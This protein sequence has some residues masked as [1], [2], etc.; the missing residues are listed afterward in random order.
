[1]KTSPKNKLLR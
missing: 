1:M